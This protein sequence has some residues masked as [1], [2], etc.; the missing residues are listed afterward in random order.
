M[1]FLNLKFIVISLI[2]YSRRKNLFFTGKIE[3]LKI[4]DVFEM[5]SDCGV[6]CFNVSRN[7]YLPNKIFI[8]NLI[9][10]LEY[11][12]EVVHY[13]EYDKFILLATNSCKVVSI[14]KMNGFGIPRFVINA[15]NTNYIVNFSLK[16][17]YLQVIENEQ[18]ILT[19]T[20]DMK[21]YILEIYDDCD[22]FLAMSL[23]YGITL[24]LNDNPL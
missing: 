5:T 9:N 14:R 21:N 3:D 12:G 6:A 15:L 13:K 11:I 8:K 4:H 24:L 18:N 23:A 1:L 10:D 20:G 22:C 17:M 7:K 2:M 19:F 16:N